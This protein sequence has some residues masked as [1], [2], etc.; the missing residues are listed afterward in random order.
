MGVYGRCLT[1]YQ[2][3]IVYTKKKERGN[4]IYISSTR[5]VYQRFFLQIHFI[6]LESYSHPGVDRTGGNPNQH[7]KPV[8][9]L[10]QFIVWGVFFLEIPS[11]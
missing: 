6:R 2:V 4:D 8:M 1:I 3:I 5:S 11:I 9:F 7:R 10:D